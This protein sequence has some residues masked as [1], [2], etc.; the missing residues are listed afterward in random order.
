MFLRQSSPQILDIGN[1]NPKSVALSNRPRPTE[2]YIAMGIFVSIS[3]KHF[4]CK[5][6]IEINEQKNKS[7]NNVS[8]K[9]CSNMLTRKL[10]KGYPE[11]W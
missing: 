2:C 5:I 8:V 4:L 1:F 3:Q 10:G 6:V 7:W 11:I 9:V